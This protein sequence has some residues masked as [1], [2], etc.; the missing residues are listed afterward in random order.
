[1]AETAEKKPERT[2]VCGAHRCRESCQRYLPGRRAGGWA[3]CLCGH[4]QAVHRPT[5]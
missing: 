1:M 5:P 4:S 2:G 3:T